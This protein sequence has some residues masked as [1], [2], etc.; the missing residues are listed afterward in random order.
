MTVQH[1]RT[2]LLCGLLPALVVAL[3]S[4]YRP[5]FLENQEFGAY[6]TLVRH[7]AAQKPE[8]VGCHVVGFQKPGGYTISPPSTH[9]ENVG[10]E[11]CHG[12][13]GP[14]TR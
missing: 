10:C 6:D 11:D 12:R 4:L 9:L 2:L 7:A 5:T 1:R 13:G 14:Q 3:L 8:C